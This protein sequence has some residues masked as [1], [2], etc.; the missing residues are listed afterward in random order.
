[1]CVNISATNEERCKISHVKNF[2]NLNKYIKR[3]RYACKCDEN[4]TLEVIHFK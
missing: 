2:I 1:M 4:K 3:V